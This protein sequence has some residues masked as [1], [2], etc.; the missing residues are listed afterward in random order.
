M[1]GGLQSGIAQ[2]IAGMGKEKSRFK[3]EQEINIE[4]QKEE[5]RQKE[6]EMKEAMRSKFAQPT[7]TDTEMPAPHVPQS[8]LQNANFANAYLVRAN[9][10]DA[11]LGN[12]NFVGANLESCA[13]PMNCAG[14]FRVKHSPENISDFLTLF[15]L[16]E[17]VDEELLKAVEPWV[18]KNLSVPRTSSQCDHPS[19]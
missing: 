12:A 19:S 15:S 18:N 3:T 9:F 5:F 16:L 1:M 17:E 13:Y 11:E 7:R 2:K 10:L 8:N 14:F 6:R 4:R